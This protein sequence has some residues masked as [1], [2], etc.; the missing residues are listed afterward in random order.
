MTVTLPSDKKSTILY[1]GQK[2]L[3]LGT[4]K[5]RFLAQFIGKLVSS[6]PAVQHGDLFYRYLEISKIE[7]LKKSA[8]NFD[9][10]MKLDKDSKLDIEW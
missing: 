9:A 8:G 4:F 7:A 6:L 2:L 10:F 3:K 5:I 1:L